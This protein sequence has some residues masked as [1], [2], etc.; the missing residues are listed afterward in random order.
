MPCRLCDGALYIA[1]DKLA[2]V[3][4]VNPLM[5]TL[6]QLRNGRLHSNTVIGTL[7]VDGRTVTFGTAMRG[8]GRL[9]PRPF[10]S[11]LYQQPNHQRL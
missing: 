1:H 8:L 9:R 10:P 5:A 3:L 6:K 11:S 7:A 2:V 4:A